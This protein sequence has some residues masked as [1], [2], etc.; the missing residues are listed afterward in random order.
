MVSKYSNFYDYDNYIV[1]Y[2]IK[3]IYN[4]ILIDKI[5]FYFLLKKLFAIYTKLLEMDEVTL[6]WNTFSYPR[7]IFD[8]DGT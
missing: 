1:L 5:S 6:I 8:N 3:K 4:S 2:D 7:F